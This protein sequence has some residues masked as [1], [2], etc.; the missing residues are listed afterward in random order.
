MRSSMRTHQLL[1]S[2][3]LLLVASSCT[4]FSFGHRSRECDPDKRLAELIDDYDRS[5]AGETQDNGDI[6]LDCDRARLEMERLALEYPGHVPTLMACAVT[7]YDAR[8]TDKAQRY[9]D[10]LFHVQPVHADA[11]VLRYRIA[12]EEGNLPYA[13]RLLETQIQYT[14]DHAGLREAHS[15]VLYMSHDLE[16]A[17]AE[18]TAAEKLGAPAWRVAFNRGLIAE[19]GGKTD[20]A[21]K[22]Y[23]AAFEA[24]PACTEAR[25]RMSGMNASTGYN[26]PTSPPGEAGGG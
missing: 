13:R 8:E 22:Q 5:K 15:A 24:N 21:R 2:A 1:G 12:V 10:T 9:L 16:G 23:K 19:A 4:S 14:P 17:S 18:I 7:A 11:A 3:L 26:R 6:L 20:E 25:S